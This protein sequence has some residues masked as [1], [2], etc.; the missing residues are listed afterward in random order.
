MQP[1]LQILAGLERRIDLNI[2]AQEIDSE[3]MARLG[4]LARDVRMPG[5]RKGKVPLKLVASS[6][7]AGVQSEVLNDKL[8]RAFQE[9]VRACNVRVAGQPRIESAPESGGQTYSFAAIFEVYPEVPMDWVGQLEVKQARCPIDD[10]A[11]DRTIDIMRK[12]RATYEPVEREARAEDHVVV[13]F[14]GTIAGEPFEG[15]SATDYTIKVGAGTMLPEFEQALPGMKAGDK[16]TFTVQ[17]PDNYHGKEVAGKQAAFEVEVK[18]VEQPVLPA[19]D[20]AFAKAIGIADG[21]LSKLREEIKANLQREVETRLKVKTRASIMEA[22]AETVKFDVPKALVA[23]EAHRL[24]EQMRTQLSQQGVDTKDLPINAE[25][26]LPKAETQV[27]LG[28]VVGELVQT[29]NLAVQ[30]N[31]LREALEKLAQ[32]YER[33]EEV[34]QWYLQDRNR[35]SEIE[36]S[37]LEENVMTWILSRVKVSDEQVAFDELMGTSG[38]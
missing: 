23:Q 28:L 18:R 14:K 4:K 12:Q 34:I 6:Y 25:L 27:R 16:K 38:L 5:F 2:P 15:G 13:D 37:V 8:G 1:N 20:E 24:S 31:Q 17:F 9:A 35:L 33:P 32:S 29:Q 7:G 36:N 30:Q 3:V 26:F 19:L 11:L 22:L 10:A 21:D